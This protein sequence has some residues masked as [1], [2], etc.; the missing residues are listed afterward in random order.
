MNLK[1]LLYASILLLCFSCTSDEKDTINYDRAQDPWVFRSVLDETPR[2]VTLALHDNLWAAYNT[3]TCALYKVWKGFVNL[4]GAV[5]TT[6]HGPQPTSIGNAYFV[7]QHRNPWQVSLDGNAQAIQKVQYRGHRF[8]GGQAQPNYE[9][10]LKNG[11]VIEICLL[12][13]S[14]SPRDS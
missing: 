7:N 9:V 12:Y 6:V 3:N 14:P 8:V 2:I 4:D 11:D 1:N 13:T 10:Q 5:Y